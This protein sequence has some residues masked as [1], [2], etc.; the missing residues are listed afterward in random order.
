LLWNGACT[1]PCD[2]LLRMA[3]GATELLSQL[4]PI[5]DVLETHPWRAV[6]R[7]KRTLR[8]LTPMKSLALF[9]SVFA[10]CLLIGC[11]GGGSNSG[12]GGGVHIAISPS[13]AVSVGVTLTQQFTAS[14][15][16]TSDTAVTWSISSSSC[17]GAACGSI[18]ASG[19]YTAPSTPPSANVIVQAALNADNSKTATVN[20]K[21]VD[22]AVTLAP[23]TAT[24]ALNGNQQFSATA[25]PGNA[26]Q[27]FNWTVT[28]TNGPCGTVDSTGLYTAP[29][30]L[31]NPTTMTV[32]AT[33]TIDPNGSDSSSIFLVSSFN[34]RLKGSNAFH[35]SGFD[36]VG[37]VLLVGSF[38]ADGSG[39]I[40]SGLED[41]SRSG[42][43]QS[44]AIT[45]G[46]YSVGSDNR[47]T[48]S[49]TTSAGTSMYKFAIGANGETEFIEFDGTGIT[50]AGVID[51]ANSASF[52]A[53]SVKGPYAFGYFGSDANNERVGYAGSFV[54]DGAGNIS[55]GSL[56]I[57]DFGSPTAST[58]GT[59]TYTVSAGTGRGTITLTVGGQTYDFAFYMVAG[60]EIFVV[61]TDSVIVH[62]RVTGLLVSQDTAPTYTAADLNASSVYYVTGVDSGIGTFSNT[63][64]GIA[65]P[66]GAGN[67]AG[68]FDQNNAGVVT[69]NSSFNSTYA[70]TGSG[71]Y[72]ISLSGVP[73]VMYAFTKN[74]GFLL[75][76]SSASV[77][78]GL[79][80]PQSNSPFS[81]NT[82]QGTFIQSNNQIA[83]KAAPNVVAAISLT[84]SSGG[85]SGTQDET[86]GGQNANQA[87]AGSYTVNS[88]GRGTS[89]TTA[90][91]STS[92]VLYIINNAKFASMENSNGNQN[93]SILLS[94][95]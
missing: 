86:D 15:T 69:S 80:E 18:S 61:S 28:C 71:R 55:G 60:S 5:V 46:T 10:L 8:T 16:G 82:I 40:T 45:G 26:P 76:Q 38:A 66:D 35:F 65:T 91:S 43:V 92:G 59:G 56:D 20:V 44:L 22:I 95:R 78:T 53:A 62:P 13:S 7:V 49:L 67:I 79:L 75:D 14:V 9:T 83:G 37:P 1:Y 74:K 68:V 48:L 84:A 6:A 29:A 57:N 63:T 21:V 64:V 24:V 42:G 88:N 34:S 11:G 30:A 72:T 50:G 32:T 70:A 87:I 54:A 25:G 52:S 23:K 81:A 58:A 47:G 94:A 39:H 4:R 77:Q 31:P 41:I 90:P 2:P 73:F 89:S 19:L 3:L 17:T 27:T 36:N 85:V 33:S 12:G 93:S 51:V